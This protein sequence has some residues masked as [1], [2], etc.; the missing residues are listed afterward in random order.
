MINKRLLDD[1][2]REHNQYPTTPERSM[3]WQ[4]IKLAYGVT[5]AK[6]QELSK[7]HCNSL[8]LYALFKARE[9]FDSTYTA[10]L[11][12]FRSEIRSDGYVSV[13]AE[14]LAKACNVEAYQNVG[15]KYFNN[16]DNCMQGIGLDSE[17]GYKIKVENISGTGSHFMAGYVENYCLYLSDSSSRGIHVKAKDVIPQS[18][19]QWI[20]EV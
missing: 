11:L 14:V 8:A 6:A 12:K 5:D 15:N 19:F 10:W 18:K 17:K 1:I 4:S 9:F 7:T 16:Y 3:L 20:C 13:V 2:I